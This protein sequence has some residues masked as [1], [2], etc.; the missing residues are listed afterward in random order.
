MT[1]TTENYD[2]PEQNNPRAMDERVVSLEISTRQ[3]YESVDHLSHALERQ[4]AQTERQIGEMASAMTQGFEK[5]NEKLAAKNKPDYPLWISVLTLFGAFFI[6]LWNANMGLDT[7]LDATRQRLTDERIRSAELDARISAGLE[8]QHQRAIDDK[9]ML[10]E[11]MD[12]T[13]DIAEKTAE[14]KY[15]ADQLKE[16]RENEPNA[17]PAP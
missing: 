17:L 4:A 2:M 1:P 16:Q 8:Y 10:K 3:L 13:A 11:R 7:Q 5:V 12:L 14:I 9:E 6:F 15:L